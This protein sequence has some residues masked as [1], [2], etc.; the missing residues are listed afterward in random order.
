VGEAVVG[1]GELEGWGAE[2]GRRGE[3]SILFE[4]LGLGGEVGV[5]C[6]SGDMSRDYVTDASRL[7]SHV[8]ADSFPLTVTTLS[9]SLSSA[10]IM[11][12]AENDWVIEGSEEEDQLGS[13][14]RDGHRSTP[15]LDPGAHPLS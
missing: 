15:L 10:L 11:V 3:G 7:A 8:D 9:L 14:E 5:E 6:E 2:L 12:G 13:S 4:D 1:R